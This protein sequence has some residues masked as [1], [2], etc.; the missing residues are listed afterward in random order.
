VAL[1][2]RRLEAFAPAQELVRAPGALAIEPPA[3]SWRALG[4]LPAALADR[5]SAAQARRLALPGEPRAIIVFEPLQYPLARSLLAL[6][7]AAE[8][9]YGG[10]TAPADPPRVTDLH[11][12]ATARAALRFTDVAE[13]W[14]RME[15]LGIESGR[16]GSERGR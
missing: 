5:I 11:V 6:H 14:E 13:L 1:L 4:R 15:A 12:A 10:T 16:L 3:L 9:W 2:P 8:L 7:E